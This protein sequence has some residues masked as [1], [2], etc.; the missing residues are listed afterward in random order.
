MTRPSALMRLAVA[1]LLTAPYLLVVAYF[2]EID[3]YHRHF[4]EPSRSYNLLR[5]V[6]AGYLFW[7]VYFSGRLC[8]LAFYRNAR[9]VSRPERVA[10]GFF[11]GAALWTLLMLPLGYLGW[12]TRPVALVVTAPIIA[13]SSGHLIEALHAVSESWKSRSGG[14]GDVRVILAALALMFA[15]LLLLVKG[16][17]PAGGHDYFTHYFY[18]YNAVIDSHNIWPNEVWYHYY[19]SKAMGLFFLSM[20]LTDP[21]APSLVSFCFA[22]ATAIA[23]FA[24]VD[25]CNPG[26]IWPWIAVVLYFAFYIFTPSQGAYLLNGGWGDFQKTHEISAAFLFAILWMSARLFSDTGPTARLWWAA[27]AACVAALAFVTALSAILAGMFFGLMGGAAALT[28]DWRKG[29][30]FFGL[31]MV[32][33]L[34]LMAVLILNYAT[35]GLPLDNGTEFFWPLVDLRK[36]Q[37]WGVLPDVVLLMA[38]RV[39]AARDALALTGVEWRD[40][41]L[42]TFRL[43]ILDR[44]LIFTGV[45]LILWTLLH[46]GRKRFKRTGQDPWLTP[47]DPALVKSAGLQLGVAAAL[48]LTTL[49]AMIAVGGTQPVSFLR[50]S[51]FVLPLMLAMLGAAWQLMTVAVPRS[52]LMQRAGDIVLSVVIFALAALFAGTTY[53][54]FYYASAGSAVAHAAAF[55]GGSASIYDSYKHQPGWAGR[56]PDGAIRPWALAV[57]KQ[58]GPGARF[59]TFANHTYCMVPGCRPEAAYSF[60]MSPRSLDIWFGAPDE[61][62]SLLRQ[63]GLNYFLVEMDDRLSDPLLCSALFSPDR[64]ANDLGMKWTDGDHTLLTWL[65]QGAAPL[66]PAWIARYREKVMEAP[67]SS[68]PI[69]QNLARELAA[70]PQWG[71]DIRNPWMSH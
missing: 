37:A 26:K 52:R 36:L 23:L 46:V 45:M 41:F 13:G 18:Y 51:S 32:A 69:F 55:A 25:R 71:A 43:E 15:F 54:S 61:A 11:V 7:L 30:A 10:L 38:G 5:V 3:V 48:I 60:R 40:F 70:H 34:A 68:M 1:V 42:R 44:L 28:G 12:Y 65:D 39:S 27:S 29:F 21:L 49:C 57:W 22:F 53:M 50:F 20:L 31:G 64:I 66:E 17:Y 56:E 58:L 63:E 47:A 19:Y 2:A 62:R 8:L 9:G 33:S 67:C 4:F 16:L 24:F 14:A 6:F 35:T 59:W